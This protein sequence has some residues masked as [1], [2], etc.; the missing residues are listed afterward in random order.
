MRCVATLLAMA[1]LAATPA[2]AA[3]ALTIGVSA[4]LSGPDAVFGDQLKLGVMQA[5]ADIDASGGILGAGAH[6]VLGDDGNDAKTGVEVANSFVDDKVPIVVGPFSSAVTG[7]A[8]A[9]YAGAGVLDITPSATA[10]LV[11]ERG[12][13]TVFRLCPRED[14]QAPVAAAYL[15]RRFG[16]VAILHDRSGPGKAVADAV[17]KALAAD[18][19]REVYYGSVDR[20]AHD[21]G[22]L[23]AR[24][25]ASGAQAVFWGGGPAEAGTV[26]RQLKEAG[27]R[28][29]LLGGFALASDEFASAAG[30]A[31]DGALVV[32]PR[33]PRTKATAAALLRRLQARNV[34]PDG[35]VFAAY[36]AVQV[37]AQAAATAMSLE[38]AA[39]ARTM[40]AG[41]T[42][43]TVLGDLAF[44]PKGDLKTPDLAI[45]VWHKGATGRMAFDEEAAS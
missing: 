10:P 11:T 19:G 18:G 25:K 17:R 30:P 23:V 38:P 15:T 9:V 43:R 22:G 32:F 26:A 33:D 45:Y 37:V 7:P 36:A 27:A 40:H 31:A 42:F 28:I 4:P 20:T 13:A 34:S 6:V 41:S 2:V 44:D 12:L 21:L 3:S 1:G 29:T 35:Y 16:R 5:V 8:S 39:L 14:T 24:L